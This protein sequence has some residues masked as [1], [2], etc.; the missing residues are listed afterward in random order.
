SNVAC[1]AEGVGNLPVVGRL[2]FGPV[3][4]AERRINAHNAVR[5]NADVTELAAD[6][7]GFAHLG[8]EGFALFFGTH[9]GAPAGWA[10]DWRDERADDQAA[11]GD[12]VGKFFQIVVGGI[13]VGVRQREENVHAV[14]LLAVHFRGGGQVE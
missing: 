2:V 10:P 13:N 8:Q 1:L 6:L 12:L 3:R 7:A 14:E 9:R 11:R 5:A 4:R